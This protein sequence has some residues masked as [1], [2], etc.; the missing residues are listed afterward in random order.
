MFDAIEI[1]ER[2]G[3][4]CAEP[5]VVK[6]VHTQTTS[7]VRQSHHIG[8]KSASNMAHAVRVADALGLPLNQFVTFNFEHT[9]CPEHLVSRQF[10]RLRDN[11]F[12]KCLARKR[13]K[14]KATPPVY[15][16]SIENSGGCLNVHW[17]VHIPKGRVLDFRARLA[18]WL[19]A[20]AG[21]VSCAS[22]ID[23]KHAPRPQG[24]IKYI[25]KGIDPAYAGFFRID[26]FPQ[27]LVH[28]KRAGTSKALGPSVRRRMQYAVQL[29]RTASNY[30]PYPTA[31]SQGPH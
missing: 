26:H 2:G 22:A 16:W 19:V 1:A 24:L 20:V 15:V 17:V 21:E 27:G 10:Q 6:M 23:V 14:A 3:T 13:G 28:G 9:A 11:H 30:R 8:R 5:L 29:R 12:G 7:G 31:P 25:S 18:E 4:L